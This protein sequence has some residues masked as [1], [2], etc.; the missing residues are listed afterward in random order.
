MQGAAER[1]AAARVARVASLATAAD[2]AVGEGGVEIRI[3][4]LE[5]TAATR[6]R[7]AAP[8]SCT[9]R[10][11]DETTTQKGCQLR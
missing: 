7:R 9:L 6:R 11:V 2:E 5:W 8:S 4:W 1:A 3:A 10:D